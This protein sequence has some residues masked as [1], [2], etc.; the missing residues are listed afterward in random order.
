MVR[1]PIIASLVLLLLGGSLSAQ[2]S[3]EVHE[4]TIIPPGSQGIPDNTGSVEFGAARVATTSQTRVFTIR[5]VG[6]Q[7]LLLTEPINVPDGFTVLRT[8]GRVIVPAGETTTFTVALNAAAAGRYA[9]G[10]LSFVNNDAPRNP[11]NFTLTGSALPEPSLRILDNNDASFRVI[12][13]WATGNGAG[14]GYQNGGRWIAAGTGTNVASWTF[15]GL[16]P[17][18]YQ[19]SATWTGYAGW[20]PDARYTI[21]DG[22]TALGTV[23]VNQQN[24]PASILDAETT[25]QHLGAPVM[26]TGDTLVVQLSDQATAGTHLHADAIRVERA[27]YL[28]SIIDSDGPGFSTTNTWNRDLLRGFQGD[29]AFIAPGTGTATW[30]FNV[31]AGSYRVSATWREAANRAT[32]AAFTVLN[33]GTPLGTVAIN[34][35]LVPKDIADGGARWTDLGAE[36]Q[37]YT[38]TGTNPLVVQLSAQGADGFVVAD[39]V[40]IERVNVPVTPT[41]HDT[42][43]F[44]DQATWGPSSALIAQ[45]QAQGIPAFLDAQLALGGNTSYPTMPVYPQNPAVRMD[46]PT[47]PGCGNIPP[48]T[49]N[50]PVCVRENYTPYWMQ[51][52]FFNSAFY[53]DD[54][55]RQRMAWALHKIVVTDSFG[56]IRNHAARYTMYLQLLDYQALANYRGLLWTLTLNPLMGDYLD[57]IRSTRASPNE[58][59]AR[60]LMQLFSI[61][62]DELHPDGTPMLDTQGNPI[63]TYNQ[64]TVEEFARALTGWNLQA[65]FAP[66]VPNW[67]DFMIVNINQH[68]LAA[69]TLLQRSPVGRSIPPAPSPPTVQYAWESFDTVMDN[70]AYHP[71]TGPY[72]CNQLIQMLVTSNPSPGYV[73]RVAAVWQRN[74]TNVD[75]LREVARA[76]LLDPEARGDLKTDPGYGK[77]REPV[78]RATGV[79]RAFGVTAYSGTGQSDGALGLDLGTNPPG[80]SEQMKVLEQNLFRPPSVFSYYPPDNNLT[81]TNLFGP[82]FQ[83]YTTLT[84][85]RYHNFTNLMT[86]PNG[87]ATADGIQPSAAGPNRPIPNGTKF[88]FTDLANLAGGDGSALVDEIDRVMLGQ[89]MTAAMRQRII[90]AIGVVPDTNTL[91]RA[92][93][94]VYLVMNAPEYQVQ[95]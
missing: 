62:L 49:G 8:F 22:A 6:N 24:W 78:Q 25:W 63:P 38:T 77:L 15:K 50:N 2:P 39:A 89:R 11:F 88:N 73:A 70:V 71:N 80:P 53:S 72:V 20:A 83:I 55:L 54:Q 35:R 69:K 76:I 43:R 14:W 75:Q 30:T 16:T 60:E 90:Q 10:Q 47:W 64:A 84:A 66:G 95:R 29:S 93:T 91:R 12:G 7:D 82:E 52:R 34:Q 67:I 42:V 85:V 9:S 68:H 3:I 56:E 58:N 74:N 17:G 44:L 4:G 41:L 65:Q 36:G 87:A 37:V 94:A 13:P 51:R 31:P 26:I 19:V 45:V 1:H 32:N 61:G 59:Y 21:R 28:G 46:D 5:N 40:R 92:K 33:G 48:L 23:V 79:A 81:G 18:L 27:G 57:M 86:N